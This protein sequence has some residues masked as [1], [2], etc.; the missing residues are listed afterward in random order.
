MIL[1]KFSGKSDDDLFKCIDFEKRYRMVRDNSIF[2]DMN[3]KPCSKTVSR[4][5]K[6]IDLSAYLK[7]KADD[8][9][10]VIGAIE[11]F[12]NVSIDIFTLMS[13]EGRQNMVRKSYKSSNTD[14]EKT[15][16]L[17]NPK[18]NQFSNPVLDGM[19]LILNLE[20]FKV[21]YRYN[22]ENDAPQWEKMSF[23]H[24]LTCELKP[25]LTGQSFFF[26]VAKNKVKWVN[27]T[28]HVILDTKKLY[29]NF[30]L[31]V[32]IWVTKK[33]ERTKQYQKVL[34]S[35]YCKK[36][37]FELPKFTGEENLSL[38]TQVI[39]YRDSSA[40]NY[41]S[42]EHKEC[43]Y[44]TNNLWRYRRHAAACFPDTVVKCSQK[45]YSKPVDD[46]KEEL[47]NE[48]II[49]SMS[50]ENM[51]FACFDIE[52]SMARDTGE[53]IHNLLMVHKLLSIGITA[54]FGSNREI[55]LLREDMNPS[56][57]EK[58]VM[59]FVATLKD[60]RNELFKVVPEEISNGIAKYNEVIRSSK[61]KIMNVDEKTQIYRKLTYLNEIF[62]LRIYSWNGG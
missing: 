44:G 35:K 9:I 46:V 1:V 26:E 15:I 13:G 2:G 43:F 23:I 59:K 32:Q 12:L 60:L 34:D 25:K 16:Q 61:F 41:F 6:S 39:Y 10:E 58:L 52:T 7:F 8:K 21:K 55:F 17:F 37:V 50:W 33:L 54:N 45:V 36:L 53:P 18:F 5:K 48:G 57:L 20:E 30:N 14:A 24:A 22:S 49:P 31:G 28:F 42:C 27:S 29:K 62:K 47:V 3:K 19:Q 51:F 4:L 56:S 11:E 40:I 38:D